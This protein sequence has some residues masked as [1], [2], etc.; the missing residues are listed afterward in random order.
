MWRITR[1]LTLVLFAL[2]ATAAMASPAAPG[3]GAPDAPPTADAASADPGVGAP[4]AALVDVLRGWWLDVRTTPEDAGTRSLTGS[5]GHHMDPN[6]SPESTDDEA[7]RVGESA[8]SAG[9]VDSPP[10][11]R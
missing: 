1:A 3:T 11:V 5:S 4:V 6:G 10:E 9:G 8:P 2:A 7:R